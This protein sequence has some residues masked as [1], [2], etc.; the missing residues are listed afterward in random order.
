MKSS[1]VKFVLSTFVILTM[2]VATDA[3]AQNTSQGPE[4]FF[5]FNYQEKRNRVHSAAPPYL[6]RYTSA[7]TSIQ[8]PTFG[9]SLG[10]G[11]ILYDLDKALIM[12]ISTRNKQLAWELAIEGAAMVDK[13]KKTLLQDT[14]VQRL[15][16][17]AKRGF[18]KPSI[19][20]AGKGVKGDIGS[21]ARIGKP[22]VRMKWSV[23]IL[24]K[25]KGGKARFKVTF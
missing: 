11:N 16:S 1:I 9:A 12:A 4:K 25:G 7:S 13:K 19:R 21:I 20:I 14:P 22:P 18:F 10:K 24:K 8:I 3:T 23:G 15:R 5:N 17:K 2:S 6:G